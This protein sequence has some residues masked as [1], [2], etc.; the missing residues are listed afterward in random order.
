MKEYYV[1][2]V[3]IYRIKAENEDR[4]EE[5]LYDGDRDPIKEYTTVSENYPL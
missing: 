5:A 1:K 2:R 4:A 3:E